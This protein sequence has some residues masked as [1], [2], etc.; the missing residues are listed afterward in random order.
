[1]LTPQEVAALDDYQAKLE[2][3]QAPLSDARRELIRLACEEYQ[4][5]F[6]ETPRTV[7]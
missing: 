4:S 7:R 1:M 5:R 2:A 3:T 6:A